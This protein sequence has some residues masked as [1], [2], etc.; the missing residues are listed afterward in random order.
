MSC[1]SDRL[2]LIRHNLKKKNTGKFF[3]Y[4]KILNVCTPANHY[5]GFSMYKLWKPHHVSSFS[6]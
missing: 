4:C 3:Y 6:L 5:S 1:E 2:F